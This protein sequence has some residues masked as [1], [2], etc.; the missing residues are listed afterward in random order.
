MRVGKV[1]TVNAG[2]GEARSPS[3]VARPGVRWGGFV[4][5]GV[6]GWDY[7]EMDPDAPALVE[8]GKAR[9][10]EMALFTIEEVRYLPGRAGL[11]LLLGEH[12]GRSFDAIISRAKL[13]GDDW[14]DRVERLS[15]V[16]AIPGVLMFD[17]VDVWT[18]GYSK[19]LTI[20][21]LG[22]AGF[23]VPPT[24]SATTVADID[25]ACAE[26]GTVI[27]KPSYG[28]RGIDVERVSDPKRDASVIEDL[29]TR[30]GTLLCEP[31]YPTEFGEYRITVAGEV[32]PI[33]MLKLP[34][35]GSWRCKTLEGASFE[36]LDAPA[37]L[38]DL[39][40]RATREMGMTLSGVDILPDGEGG[41]VILEVNPIPGFLNIFGKKA[42]Q[43][44][45]DGV[46]D[47]VEKRVAER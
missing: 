2:V 47:W 41:Y 14:R 29:L 15:L 24:R 4:K 22:Q 27:V 6:L 31:Y 10:H 23:P 19:F 38:L 17:P 32:A 40:V 37:D 30:H 28:M 25:A 44:T 42:H 9:G 36:R 33:N 35:A 18:T 1:L 21:K 5:I 7:G 11:D 13:F 26:W 12:E 3:S 46:F 39:A 8:H 43:Q 16:S 34:A 20:A 45:L